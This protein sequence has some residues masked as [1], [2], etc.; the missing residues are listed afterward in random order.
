V[1]GYGAASWGNP[2][3]DV[4]NP[5]FDVTPAK[6]VSHWILDTGVYTKADVTAGALKVADAAV[7]VLKE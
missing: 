6:L 4:W 7:R 3:S 1:L 2:T 5:A